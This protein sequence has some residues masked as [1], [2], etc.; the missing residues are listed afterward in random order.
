MIHLIEFTFTSE[1]AVPRAYARKTKQYKEI[2]ETLTKNGWRVELHVLIM[3][4]RGWMPQHT[5]DALGRLGVT[6]SRRQALYEGLSRRAVNALIACNNARRKWE[7]RGH[8]DQTNKTESGFVRFRT[9]QIE[10]RKEKLKERKT[11]EK[12]YR[13]KKRP[14][15][16]EG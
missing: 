3:G 8:R 4:V 15:K 14:K 1:Q 2:I 7:V 9:D 11:A 16:G 10:R 6:K 12:G 5:W 13:N